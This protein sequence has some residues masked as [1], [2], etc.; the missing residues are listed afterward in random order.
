MIA[1]GTTN[2]ELIILRDGGNSTA[3]KLNLS[4]SQTIDNF[5]NVVM[6]PYMNPGR[7]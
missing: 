2:G 3:L 4:T 6:T 1:A 5:A 7:I